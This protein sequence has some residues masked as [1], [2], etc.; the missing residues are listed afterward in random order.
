MI[1]WKL[2]EKS[3]IRLFYRGGTSNP[4]VNQL[5]NVI[6]FNNPLF[7]TTGNPDL[8]QSVTNRLGGRYTYTNSRKGNSFFVNVFS[9]QADNYITNA[10]YTPREDSVLTP[11]FTLKPGSQLSKPINLNGYWNLNTLL[12]YSFP[13]KAIKSNVTFN[14]GVAYIKTPGLINNVKNVSD[15]YVYSG[16]MNIA[17]NISEYVDFNINYNASYNIA[18][19][20]IQPNLNNNYFSQSAG[21]GLNLMTKNG[22]V[23]TNDVNNQLYSGLTGGLD[24]NYWLWNMAVAKKF[25]KDQKGELRLSVF[26]L[27]KQNRS[28]SRT[29]QYNYIEDN[30]TRVL[31]QYFMLTFS[32]RIKNFGKAPQRR[33]P[34]RNRDGMGMPWN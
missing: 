30:E 34:G 21:L 10:T 3:N 8:E 15:N 4:S 9:N 5:Q 29:V 28:I 1:R 7:A 6:N 31:T 16:G 26:D 12:T 23:F 20:E 18:R 14:G 11:T 33:E 25:L 22:W 32:Y 17:S 2:G 13:F 24:Q 27:L 19:N